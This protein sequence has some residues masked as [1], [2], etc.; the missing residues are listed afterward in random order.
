MLMATVEHVPQS[1]RHFVRRLL[2]MP[3][4]YKVLIANSTLIIIG[5]LGGTAL[6][7]RSGEMHGGWI[8][9]VF[10]VTGLA[11]TI[12]FNT[13]IV[14]AALQPIRVLSCTV[15][16]FERGDFTARVPYSPVA[17]ADL[18]N[19]SIALNSMIEHI[20]SYQRQV[21]DLS[22]SVLEAQE[23]ERYRIARELHDQIGQSLT[24]LLVR[25]KI[26][27]AAPQSEPLRC[28][29]SELRGA[30]AATIDQVRRLALEL[31]PPALDQLGLIVA[32]RT[33]IREFAEQTRIVVTSAI[34][35]VPLSLT[36]ER[37]TALYRIVQEALTNIA[38]H[39][40]ARNAHVTLAID[41]HAITVAISDD[42]RGFDLQT[43]RAQRKKQEGPGL[44]LFGMEE[45]TR[46]LGGTMTIKTKSGNGTMIIAIIPIYPLEQQHVPTNQRTNST[47][48]SYITSR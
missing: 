36:N 16:A 28:E 41:N 19:V 30:V 43:V 3:L 11:L 42:G 10:T 25:L 5:A 48:H 21:Q 45:R 17:D 15:D 6:A 46:L 34:P 8:I 47:S 39:A 22:G 9:V 27:E 26:L 7:L 1:L 31:R 12:A 40:E 20:Q 35:D 29:L 4:F 2:S 44:G 32:L 24:L 37:A 14:H 18:S 13:L 33:L 38:R 23:D